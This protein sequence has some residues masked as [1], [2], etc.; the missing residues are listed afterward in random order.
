ML[1]QIIWLMLGF[2]GVCLE[3]AQ[4]GEDKGQYNGVSSVIAWLIGLWILY[5]GGFFD[6]LF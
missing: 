1:P 2:G 4:H 3:I 6:C 5:W